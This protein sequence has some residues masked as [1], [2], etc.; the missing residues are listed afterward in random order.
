M[1]KIRVGIAETG[2]TVGIEGMH[3][4]GYASVSGAC[5]LVALYAVVPGRAAR[6]AEEKGLHVPLCDRY[7]EL[8]DM[9]DL[10]SRCV[11][12][13]QH[14]PL[15]LKAYKA[16][17]HVLPEKPVSV[18]AQTARAAVEAEPDDRIHMVGFCYR[19]IPA[20]RS[21]KRVLDSGRMG[22]SLPTGRRWAAAALP[23]MR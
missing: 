10:V 8:L 4:R 15:L 20:L 23:T 18:D 2:Y 11:P 5:E 6:W 17:K 7:E 3:V 16:H 21:M 19:G 12:N 22:G 14:I 1:D 9:V 13:D